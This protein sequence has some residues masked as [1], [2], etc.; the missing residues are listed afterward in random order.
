MTGDISLGV[1]GVHPEKRVAKR[2]MGIRDFI[3]KNK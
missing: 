3:R 2:K 1:S